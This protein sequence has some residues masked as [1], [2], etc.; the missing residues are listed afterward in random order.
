MVIPSNFCFQVSA[1]TL[2]KGW[3]VAA[4]FFGT[5]LNGGLGMKL[6]TGCWAI[7]LSLKH[8]SLFF[9]PVLAF[10]LLF[11]LLLHY[12]PLTMV[13]LKHVLLLTYCDLNCCAKCD[14]VEL[15]VAGV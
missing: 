14:K 4:H 8:L 9:S 6:Y 11:L 3:R 10:S 15:R 5:L 7:P 2:G 12:F 1:R 13:N